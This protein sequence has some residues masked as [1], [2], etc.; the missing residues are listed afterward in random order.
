MPSVAELDAMPAELAARELAACC[1]ATRW[2]RGMLARRP[3]GSREALL[4]AADEV[5]RG[6]GPD[7]WHEAFSH[8]PRIGERA[9]AAAAPARA[10]AWSS[11]EQAGVASADDGVRA[12]LA[13]GNR[14]YER[15]FGFI[16][17]VC[18]AGKSAR[19]LLDILHA[20]LGSDRE[21]ELR[22]AAEEQR[23]ITRLRLEKLLGGA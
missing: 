16:Y 11:A 5:W 7:D 3:F 15:R 9:S 2:V 8:H 17:V 21:T 4:D 10:G 23:K 22:A 12:A 20:R 13:E 18:A 19:E 1:G 6:L 14:E